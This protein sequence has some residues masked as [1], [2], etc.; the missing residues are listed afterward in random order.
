MANHPCF[1][2]VI[3]SSATR[4]LRQSPFLSLQPHRCFEPNAT[5]IAATTCLWSQPLRENDDEKWLA[6][7]FLVSFQ[8][9]KIFLLERKAKGGLT[10]GREIFHVCTPTLAMCGHTT[11]QHGFG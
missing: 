6:L 1:Q 5:V 3:S 9:E 10:R 7:E 2:S 4:L 11:T 8:S